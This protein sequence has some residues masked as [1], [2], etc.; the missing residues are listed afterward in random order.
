MFFFII[1]GYLVMLNVIE[2]YLRFEGALRSTCC[3]TDWLYWL[4]E[5]I[6]LQLHFVN[7]SM[8][9]KPILASSLRVKDHLTIHNL[10]CKSQ[11]LQHVTASTIPASLHQ[12]L[13]LEG[14]FKGSAF[15]HFNPIRSTDKHNFGSED[16]R[17][18]DQALAQICL[19]QKLTK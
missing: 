8:I 5:S 18:T 1:I 7:V 4:M 6:G 16:L 14:Y 15:P 10:L 11:R 9:T 3:H 2:K 19:L 13:L 17:S 12:P